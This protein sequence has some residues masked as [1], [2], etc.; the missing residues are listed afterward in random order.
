MVSPASDQRL[1]AVTRQIQ[2]DDNRA[3]IPRR[4]IEGEKGILERF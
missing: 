2:L 4:A 1:E 3:E